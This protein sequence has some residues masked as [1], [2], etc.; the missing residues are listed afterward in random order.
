MSDKNI[1]TCAIALNKRDILSRFYVEED[2]KWHREV[3]ENGGT[4]QENVEDSLRTI[5]AEAVM[6]QVLVDGVIAGCFV[7][8]YNDAGNDVL[9]CFHVASEF[10]TKEF[11]IGFWKVVKNTF[12]D[13]FWLG[14]YEHNKEAIAHCER[15]GFQLIDK[16]GSGTTRILV[17]KVKN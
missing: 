5:S 10:R 11:L 9:E 13:D 6:Y 17:Y 8:C 16:L 14:L 2:D 15:Q 12:G 4:A 3:H 1:I 7:K